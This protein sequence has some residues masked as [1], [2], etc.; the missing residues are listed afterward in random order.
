MEIE[1]LYST[2]TGQFHHTFADF[3]NR[4]RGWHNTNWLM[5]NSIFSPTVLFVKLYLH[6][7]I[8]DTETGNANTVVTTV[9]AGAVGGW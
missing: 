2:Q 5:F 9:E 6:Y 8:Y 3:V 4:I 1:V 7:I